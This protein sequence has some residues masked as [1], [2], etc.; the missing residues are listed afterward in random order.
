MEQQMDIKVG[1]KITIK[2]DSPKENW[3][4]SME[5]LREGEH[6]VALVYDE[7]VRVEDIPG[8][9]YWSVR[10]E[11]FTKVQ[12]EVHPIDLTKSNVWDVPL[13]GYEFSDNGSDWHDGELYAVIMREAYSYRVLVADERSNCFKLCRLKAMEK[14]IKPSRPMTAFEVLKLTQSAVYFKDE[15]DGEVTN[16]CSSIMNLGDIVYCTGETFQAAENMEDIEWLPLETNA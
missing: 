3:V 7:G 13:Q 4:P 11:D 1:D 12:P 10:T 15:L 9:F 5:Y 14:A 16:R 2:K 8:D 6:K